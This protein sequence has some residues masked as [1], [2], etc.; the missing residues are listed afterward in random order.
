MVEDQIVASI[1]KIID[2]SDS[3]LGNARDG[4]WEQVQQ[5]E[6]KRQQLFAQA[7]P[8]DKDSITDAAALAAQIQNIIDLDKQTMQLAAKD[9]KEFAGLMGKLS[10]G[11][12]AVAAYQKNRDR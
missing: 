2:L 1:T 5:L 9:R 12:Q 8:L 6:Q 4:K 10:S 3:M 7:F 11:R